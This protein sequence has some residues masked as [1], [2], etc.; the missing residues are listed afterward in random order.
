MAKNFFPKQFC[1]IVLYLQCYI[2]GFF[3]LTQIIMMIL[4]LLVFILL[5][6]VVPAVLA[7]FLVM[8]TLNWFTNI[9]V[10]RRK[11]TII[12]LQRKRYVASSNRRQQRTS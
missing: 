3:I 6:E 7:S 9:H 12:K 11:I 1:I 5:P 10:I 2:Y 8:Q 4:Y